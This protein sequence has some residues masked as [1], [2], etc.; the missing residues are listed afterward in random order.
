MMQANRDRVPL[1]TK[2]YIIFYGASEGGDALRKVLPTLFSQSL[3]EHIMFGPARQ[4]ESP[5]GAC[6]FAYKNR[7]IFYG[8]SEGTRTP[9]GFLPYG[10]EPYASAN[11]ATLANMNILSLY[12]QKR[13][14]II[15]FY[16]HSTQLFRFSHKKALKY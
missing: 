2:L 4:C 14:F 6:S 11:F 10:P 9:T 3:G 13:K 12:K 1:L 16:L 8:A 15:M 5:G 7:T